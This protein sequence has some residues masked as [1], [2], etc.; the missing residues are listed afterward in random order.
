MRGEG[1][2]S[3]CYNFL[4]RGLWDISTESVSYGEHAHAWGGLAEA[5]ARWWGRPGS[6]PLNMWTESV[7]AMGSMRVSGARLLR[8][9]RGVGGAQ[10]RRR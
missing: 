4:T 1:A 8:Q 3:A 5:G 7:S 9:V 6:A 10:A 2:G